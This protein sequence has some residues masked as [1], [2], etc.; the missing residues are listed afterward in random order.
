MGIYL[1]TLNGRST[2]ILARTAQILNMNRNS[3]FIYTG[4][5]RGMS[6]D[7]FNVTGNSFLTFASSNS[8]KISG[9]NYIEAR[10]STDNTSTL[11]NVAKS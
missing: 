7:K 4:C 8:T 5:I 6:C 1:S 10:N 11:Y 2:D 9:F 3:P